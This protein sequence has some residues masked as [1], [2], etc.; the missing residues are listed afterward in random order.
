[1]ENSYYTTLDLLTMRNLQGKYA[2]ILY[3]FAI[4][5]HKVKLPE[6]TIEELREPTG[7]SE[8]KSYSNFAMLKKKVLEPAVTE[9]NRE[10]DILLRYEEGEK[11]K[12]KVL[13]VRFY[14]QKKNK[15]LLEDE[16]TIETLS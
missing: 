16:I 6:L 14:V 4:R 12:K 15:D 1:M 13:T 7:T 11:F 2:I 3:E 8:V 9:I 10:T 5:Y